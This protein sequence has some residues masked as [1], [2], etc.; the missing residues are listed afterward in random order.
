MLLEQ[1]EEIQRQRKALA[2]EIKSLNAEKAK[3]SASKRT[4][5]KQMKESSK[6]LALNLE[7]LQRTLSAKIEAAKSHLKAKAAKNQVEEFTQ[8]MKSNHAK[9]QESLR[10]KVPM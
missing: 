9:H 3:L 2:A 10:T 1:L 4:T 5:A 6:E 7:E 8:Y